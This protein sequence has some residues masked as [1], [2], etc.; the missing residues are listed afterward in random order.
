MNVLNLISTVCIESVMLSKNAKDCSEFDVI[1]NIKKW[2]V[3]CPERLEKA[4][5]KRFV[6]NFFI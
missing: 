6:I 1:E 4:E 3:R 2:L 5:K